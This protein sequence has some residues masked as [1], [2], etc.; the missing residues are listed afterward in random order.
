MTETQILLVKNSW[1]LL[2]NLDY[3]LIGD[4]FY[5]KLF[6]DAPQLKHL[7]KNSIQVQSKKLIE[8]LNFIVSHLDSMEKLPDDISRLAIRDIKY[9]FHPADY[10]AVGNALLWTLRHGL[11]R[12]WNEEVKE[13]WII[14]YQKVVAAI[15]NCERL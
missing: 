1:R 6:V 7:F 9:G 8:M 15:K 10:N 12:D 2:R 13:A 3:A 14:C 4:V 5:G 11:G